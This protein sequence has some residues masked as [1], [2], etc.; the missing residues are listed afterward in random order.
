[1]TPCR[2]A[3]RCRRTALESGADDLIWLSP[4]GAAGL[5]AGTYQAH[6][7]ATASDQLSLTELFEAYVR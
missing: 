3:N 6:F 5:G 4:H 1:M 2:A 7:E